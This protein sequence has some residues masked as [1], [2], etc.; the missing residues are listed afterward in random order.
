MTLSCRFLLAR[1]HVSA[2]SHRILRLFIGSEKEA[3]GKCL[4]MCMLQSRGHS[5]IRRS[6]LN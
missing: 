5:K 2:A 4:A 3:S 1:L 6:A